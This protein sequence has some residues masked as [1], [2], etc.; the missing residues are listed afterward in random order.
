VESL[1]TTQ[2]PDWAAFQNQ[3]AD[4]YVRAAGA[5][6]RRYCGWHIYPSVTETVTDLRIGSQGIIGLPSMYVTAVAS[7]ALQTPGPLMSA[8]V[9]DPGSYTWFDYGVIESAAALGDG[10]SGF[11]APALGGQFRLATVTF[12]HGYAAVPDAVK[13]VV[14]ELASS[15]LEVNTGNVK[16]VDT[17]GF[18]LQPTQN[19]GVNLNRE[20]KSR[21]GSYAVPAVR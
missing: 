17:P 1:L 8:V 9:L 5:E 3:D 6:V 11:Y 13:S 10:W 18:R 2:D 15:A 12:T 14:F 20:Q 4:F 7:V 16:S 21:L 19:F